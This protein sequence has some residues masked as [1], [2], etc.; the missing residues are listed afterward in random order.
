MEKF[1]NFE[2]SNVKLLVEELKEIV[3]NLETKYNVK[4][5]MGNTTYGNFDFKT[6]INVNLVKDEKDKEYVDIYNLDKYIGREFKIPNKEKTYFVTKI[7][8]N[9]SVQIKSPYGT[10]YKLD[11]QTL[12]KYLNVPF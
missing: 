9:N 6:S 3:K 2:K 8:N 10:L 1:N 7:L 12:E 5:D 4:V 11:I